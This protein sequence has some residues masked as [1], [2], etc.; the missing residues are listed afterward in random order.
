M[1]SLKKIADRISSVTATRQLTA[2]MK[3]VAVS[4]LK[5]KH[6]TFLRSVPYAD[7]SNRVVRRLVRAV[8]EQGNT[9]VLPPLLRDNPMARKYWVLTITSDNGLSGASQIQVAQQTKKIVD[10]LIEQGKE[11]RL[12][13]YGLRGLPLLKRFYPDMDISAFRQKKTTAETVPAL[14]EQF[15]AEIMR[16]FEHG[17]FDVCLIVYNQFNSLVSQRPTIDQF[18]P[19]KMFLK[20]NPWAFLIGDTAQAKQKVKPSSFLKAI[21]G[22]EVL[23]SLRNII[24]KTDLASG[25]R[26]PYLYDYEPAAVD[27]LQDMLPGYLSAYAYRVLLESEI[28]DNAARL[29]AM[30]N[31]TR[32]AGEMLE[33]LNKTYRRNRQTKI[34]TDIAEV[35]GIGKE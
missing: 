20:E 4:R 22:A 28:S 13:S 7:E 16:A 6:A 29:M 3:M 25:K 11:V 35:S 19:A 26:S 34:T 23:S 31:A 32:N 18:I 14:A 17:A 5:K 1:S 27:L 8:L 33:K 21:G 9:Q 2:S 10:Y 30:D 15:S 12:M 24:F